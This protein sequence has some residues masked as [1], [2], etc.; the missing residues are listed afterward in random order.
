MVQIALA[1]MSHALTNR[2]VVIIVK[3]IRA[4]LLFAP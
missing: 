4:I 2:G 3:R 1:K